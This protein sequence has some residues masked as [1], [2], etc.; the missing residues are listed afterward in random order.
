MGNSN[1]GYRTIYKWDEAN[2]KVLN[3]M[4]RTIWTKVL[5][6]VDIKDLSDA[7]QQAIE[8][9]LNATDP[10]TGLDTQHGILIDQKGVH[11]EGGVIEMNTT[12]GEEYLHITQ[13]GIA[14]SGMSAPNVMPR[15]DGPGVLHVDPEATAEQIEARDYFR[16]IQD[17]L[18]RINGRYVPGNVVVELK[19]GMT[20][21]DEIVLRG[22]YFAAG[23]ALRGEADAHAKIVGRLRIAHCVGYIKVQYVDVNAGAGEK[24]VYVLGGSVFAH[25]L[26]CVITGMGVS[27][28]SGSSGI[29]L[30]DGARAL[31]EEC[32]MYDSEYA[33]RLNSLSQAHLKGN[34][35]NCRYGIDTSLAY[36]S[37][38]A[39]CNQSEFGFTY[40][41][42]GEGRASGVTVDQGS[43]PTESTGFP[44]VASY[45]LSTSGSYAS[46]GGWSRFE[47]KDVR[48]G[49]TTSAGTITGCMW[50]EDMSGLKGKEILQANL[51][52]TRMS[53]YGRSS[54][55]NAVLYGIKGRYGE[56]V[57]PQATYGA[58]GAVEAG[59]TITLTIPPEAA[60]AL[61]NGTIDGLALYTNED[62]VY[63]DRS[64]SRNY[65]RFAG[66]T[67]GT[68]TSRPEIT[69]IYR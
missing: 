17:A 33:V 62:Q 51:R 16:S 30:Q 15:Y 38:T 49:Y 43:V 39:P 25:V 7:A 8:M 9:K 28:N 57:L 32:E 60:Q 14:A 64:Y 59:E 55:V 44:Q 19:G 61:A 54:A 56:G 68:G 58:I 20:G 6:H 18:D 23:F 63:K 22:A 3:D 21:Y 66:E 37:G 36:I 65:A 4:L 1:W 31:I 46:R 47:D 34:K 10:A 50:F 45:A 69:V 5:G 53:G 11:I 27:G 41:N 12:D 29:L 26:N 67:S 35:G 40:W 24:G 2:L 42:N 13:G 48:Q 52:L